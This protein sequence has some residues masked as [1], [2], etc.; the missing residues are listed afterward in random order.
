[1]IMTTALVLTLPN[2]SKI[3]EVETDAST[4]GMGVILSQEGHPL[5]VL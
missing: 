1:M 5:G 3:V 4:T 2:F